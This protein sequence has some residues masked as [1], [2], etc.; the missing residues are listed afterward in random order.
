MGRGF[1]F[2]IDALIAV[3]IIMIL[4]SFIV[5]T[6]PESHGKERQFDNFKKQ[7]EDA[8]VVGYYLGQSASSFGM[9]SELSGGSIH[10]NCAYGF[11]YSWNPLTGPANG[12]PTQNMNIEKYCMESNA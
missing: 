11:D 3:I 7:T 12:G 9:G 4:A 8:S 10:G 2:T 6:Y 5:L 1:A